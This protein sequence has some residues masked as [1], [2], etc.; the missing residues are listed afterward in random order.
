MTQATQRLHAATRAVRAAIDADA[1]HGAVTPS[2]VLSANF[3]FAGFGKKRA[4]DYTRSGNPTRDALAC[5]LAELEGGAG[6]VVTASGMAAVAL[7]AQALLPHGARV[8]LAHDAYGGTW[9]LFNALASRGTIELALADLTRGAPDFDR[10][11]ALVWIETPSNP[12]LRI[13]DIEPIVAAAH[14]VGA[15]VVVDN[16]FLSPA[17]QQPL[18][19]GADLVVHSTTKYVNGHSDVV[20]GAV[21]ARDAAVCERLAWWA[22]A[23]GVAGSPF[24]ALLT[25]RGLRTLD[26]RLAVHERNAAALVGLLDGHEAVA[27]TWWPGLATHPGHDVARRQQA[28][29]G[30]ML[31]FELAGGEPAVRALVDGLECFTLAESLGGVESLVAHPATMTH[32]SMSP[33]A[34]AGAG[35][36]PGL[37]RVSAGIEHADDLVADLAAGLARA[38]LACERRKRA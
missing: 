22:N 19:L 3:S 38:L 26:A 27:A 8:V 12:L 24:D 4:Y 7:V 17:L 33:E 35:I 36:G 23:T 20:G 5:A 37:V 16:T 13:T 2:L 9:R 10:A 18:A 32:A 29:F 34:R 31:S 6:G 28:G 30:G 21:V 25:L 1:A 15:L 11:T 14:A